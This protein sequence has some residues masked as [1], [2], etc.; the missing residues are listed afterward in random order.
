MKYKQWLT[1][2]KLDPKVRI[3]MKKNESELSPERLDILKKESFH[4]DLQFGTAGLRGEIGFGTNRMNVHVVARVSESLAQ[5]VL[6]HG[7][8]DEGVVIGYDVRHFSREF[9]ETT[10]AVLAHHGIKVYLFKE[11]APTPLVSYAIRELGTK[12]G[13][14]IT[15]S[16]NP[17][18]YNGYKVYW[19]DGAQIKDEIADEIS[20]NMAKIKDIFSVEKAKLT[21][22]NFE[23]VSQNLTDKYLMSIYNLSLSEEKDLDKEISLVYSPLNGTGLRYVREIL[24]SRGF[25]NLHI[26]KEQE[27]EDP[28]FTTLSSPNPED[29]S[30]YEYSIKLAKENGSDLIITTDPDADRIGVAVKDGE[31]YEYLNGNQIG[32]LLTDYILMMKNK[33]EGFNKNSKIVNTIVTDTLADKIAESYGLSVEKVH[34][35]FKNIYSL[36]KEWERNSENEYIFGY[37]ESLG[38]GI[39]SNI[40]RDKDAVSAAMMIVEMAAYHKNNGLSILERYEQL[41]KKFGY[42]A[43]E[44]L[45]ITMK[46]ISGIEQ[47]KNAVKG[48]RNNPLKEI[49]EENLVNFTDYLNDETGLEKLDVIKFEYSEGT[50]FAIR[51]SGTEP[52]LKV[53]VYSSGKDKFEAN[54]KILLAKN[55]ISEKIHEYSKVN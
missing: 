24:L 5:A 40:A 7:G 1:S 33:Y 35:G 49:G 42:H 43:E 44:M 37:E 11:T 8:R 17:A 54:L 15:A 30:A 46:G 10:A 16:H 13:V 20:S 19:E 47:I 31:G 12:A 39:G 51:P 21:S 36:V 48:F 27:E 29:L 23:Y 26:V 41:E 55:T 45:S 9:A 25:N 52:K 3:L 53:Y 2:D 38:F 6:A 22:D 14:M 34:V 18:E 32:A 28:D 50:W 4:T